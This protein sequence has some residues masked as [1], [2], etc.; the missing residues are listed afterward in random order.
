M[1][2]P[3]RTADRPLP[4]GTLT[5]LFSDIE[6]STRLL[7]SLGDAFLPVLERH[8]AL[9]RG[10]FEDAGGT[11]VATE[12]DSFFVVFRSAPA[13][14]K[15]AAA[16]QRAL[17]TEPWP[18][19]AGQVRV[20]MG[21]HTG[22]GTRGG[23]NY[24]GLDVNRAARIG[25][26]AHGGQVLLSD[27]TRA[28]AAG[29]LPVDLR[30]RDLGEH[31]L[32]D[33]DQPERLVQLLIEGLPAE[34]PPPRTLETPSN[35]PAQMTAFI[36]RRREADEVAALVR[37][38]RL[39]TLSGP[40]GTGKTRLAL[41][42]ATRLGAA[43][44]GG[45]FF[46]DLSP[47]TEAALIPASIAAALGVRE[48]PDRS[49][50][51]TLR[52]H[53]RD[54]QLLLVLD[55]FEQL[56]AGAPFV[57]QLLEAAPH[58]IVLVTSREVLHVRGEQEYPV[59][60][61]GLPN[62]AS[63]P[64]IDGLSQYDAVALFIQRAQAVRPD[65]A[66]DNQNAPAVAAICA[67]LDGLPLAIELAAARVKVLAPDAILAR[68]EKS[69]SLLTSSSRDLSERQRTLRGAIDWSH[70]LL[71]ATERVLFRRLGIFVGGC[72]IERAQA[73]CDPDGTLGVDMLD[74][75]SSLVD[76]SLLRHVTGADG[77]PRFGMLETVREYAMERLVQSPDWGPMRRGHG[78]LFSAMARQSSEAILGPHQK[79]WTD[80]LESERDN[81]RAA[82]QRLA[83]DGVTE[84]ALDMGAA[85]WRFW[86]MR[87]NLAEGR[88]TLE[89]LLA[90]PDAAAPTAGRARAL[91]ALGGLEY[92]QSDMEAAER[93][94]IEGLAIERS[95][96]DPGGLAE[97]LYNLGYVRAVAGEHAAARALYEEA[98]EISKGIGDRG[99]ILRL[100]E[101]LAFLMFHMG[102]FAAARQLQ[103][104]NLNAFRAGGETF[105]AAVGS[106]FL[107]YLEAKEGR[108]AVARAM[109]RE[110]LRT[111]RA[112]GD[113]HWIVRVMMLAAASAAA[114]GDLEAAAELIGAYDVLRAP[115]GEI[116]T[117]FKTLNLPDPAVQ[118]RAGLGD[119][120]FERAHAAGQ[121]MTLDEV[122]A[123]LGEPA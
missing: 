105:R 119:A 10:A 32:K 53:L 107:S 111:F 103:E 31:R 66:V 19:K 1:A 5:F 3:S 51:E 65:F 23:D 92:W 18:P 116:A 78:D 109:Q 36:G 108:Y 117:P 56:Q 114:A 120:A 95:L 48:E 37:R 102:E 87:G 55:N 93:A 14:V 63:L 81:L 121:A 76:K 49:V 50:L 75:L 17:A 45:A 110:A 72:S 71:D 16:A 25:A 47:L 85:L 34:F 28:L 115:L 27:T 20:R 61:L 94:Y 68:L 39:V 88:S 6:G 15:A 41:D 69:L 46:V 13:A 99:W 112:A 104:D 97:A 86:Q 79:E 42:V 70:D 60:P 52:V 4:T 64:P 7:Q 100:Q 11:E 84:R 24:T 67:R 43:F 90:R 21:L 96:D 35:L 38:S 62:L 33:L 82:L 8:Q 29:S 98:L 73:I 74:A 59:P 54:L 9:L 89:E 30:L 123:L 12:G 22:E 106:G 26:A 2:D 118:A 113:S 44:S 122:G 77:E 101:A 58:L 57:G 80:R 83:D 40:G 91:S